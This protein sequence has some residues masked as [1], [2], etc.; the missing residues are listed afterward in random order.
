MSLVASTGGYGKTKKALAAGLLIANV[1]RRL[2]LIRPSAGQRIGTASVR[3]K[4]STGGN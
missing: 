1:P 4:A 3:T 2:L